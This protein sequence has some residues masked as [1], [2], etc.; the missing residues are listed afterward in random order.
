M[1]KREIKAVAYNLADEI[2]TRAQPLIDKGMDRDK[3]IMLTVA[4]MDGK[5]QIVKG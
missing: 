2:L 1:T 3:A 4:Q 5:L